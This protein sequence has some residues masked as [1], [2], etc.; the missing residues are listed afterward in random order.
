M[1]AMQSK[2]LARAAKVASSIVLMAA[3]ACSGFAAVAHAGV[4]AFTSTNL[5]S[6]NAVLPAVPSM[7]AVQ[8]FGTGS[9]IIPMDSGAN[10]QNDGMLRAYGLVYE[11]LR[12]GVP[13]NWVIN[14]AKPAN[15]TDFTIGAPNMVVDVRTGSVLAPRSY[16]GGP[17]VI[18]AADAAAAMPIIFTWQAAAG[19]QTA[20]HTITSGSFNGDVS[21]RLVA[22]PRIAVLKDGGEG[23]AF[24]NINAAG[25]RDS[26]GSTWSAASP[27]QLTEAAVAGPTTAFHDDGVLF[28]QP[29]HLPRYSY[30]AGM[31]Y[32]AVVTPQRPEVVS[33][34]RAWL[35]SS[36][37]THAFMQCEAA[38][39]VENIGFFLTTAGI[40]DD[41]GSA[42]TTPT[43]RVPTSPLTQIDGSFQV[44]S[45]QV[46]SFT[47]NGGLYKTGVT[48]LINESSA[49]FTERIVELTGRMD[50]DNSNGRVTYLAGH[51]Y[52]TALPMSANPQTNGVRLMLNTIFESDAATTAPTDTLTITQ[53][54][55]ASTNASTIPYSISYS[56]SGTRPAENIRITDTI[57]AGTT[58]VA[59]SATVAPT[60]ISGNV[61]T[62]DVPALAAGGSASITY[63]V[64]VTT[65]GSYTNAAQAS[66]ST[67]TV[68]TANAAPVTTVRDTIPPAVAITAGPVGTTNDATPTFAFT[69]GG[70]PVATLCRF[71][72]DAP[73]PCASTFTSVF[74]LV[75][76]V[77]TFTVTV[78]D[79]AGNTGMAQSTFTVSTVVLVSIGVTPVNSSIPIGSL[80]QFAAF[81]IYSDGST[82]DLTD[83]VTWSSSSPTVAQISNAFGSKGLATGVNAGTSTIRA[84][85]D[86][87][88]GSTTLTVVNPDTDGDGVPNGTDNCPNTF[89]PDQRDTNNDGVGDLCTPF[90]Y[91]AGGQFVI[92]NLVSI[93]APSVN[94][95]GSQWSKNNPMTGGSAPNA[96]KG[97]ADATALPTCGGTWTS[98]PGNSSN[99]PNTVPTNMAVIVSSS[100]TKS[101][102]TISG[103]I[104]KIVIVRTNP[105]YGPAPGKAGTGKVIAVLC[106]SP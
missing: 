38:R 35:D 85:L 16:A 93:S 99:P 2:V 36:S 74:P 15:G 75:D 79:A 21:R 101:G 57:P 87:V 67:L 42:T 90:Q 98:R 45:G 56:V 31:H 61:I 48:T 62:W 88:L 43:T 41:G 13:V 46:D 66:Y 9:L 92:G 71:D 28:H 51:D 30:L 68:A 105:G 47:K 8:T 94:F 12:R 86:S 7:F 49:P 70:S 37:L 106:E 26:I 76:G 65:D 24:I 69:T 25:I 17:F 102:S 34:M 100:I 18:D 54:A 3:V 14:P 29:S 5:S 97:F 27:D 80:R 89:N 11:L 22:A 73:V 60:S 20:V 82:Q 44:D 50:G 81:G 33:E 55:P 91:P 84:T 64:S 104:K 32:S 78:T 72:S 103:N 59:G 63:S 96:F 53:T 77:H 23:I 58:Y 39:V 10:G 19:D 95:W 52:S 83:S 1:R 4:S 40:D 6:N